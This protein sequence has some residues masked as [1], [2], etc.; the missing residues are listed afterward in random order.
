[1]PSTTTPPSTGITFAVD[2]VTPATEPLKQTKAH[3]AI[4][5]T[6]RADV[7]ACSDFHGEV[8]ADVNYHP[9]LAA[10]HTAFS[11]HRPLVLTPDAVWVTIAQ[12]VA[13]HMAVH[14]EKLRSRFVAHA[15][16]LDL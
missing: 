13:Q 9:L 11:Q 5:R 2:D 12:G 6:S 14:G 16:K 8:I 15:D 4:R 3:D 1:M 10:V 7:T